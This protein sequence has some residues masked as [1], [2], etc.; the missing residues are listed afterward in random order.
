MATREI[1]WLQKLLLNLEYP[2]DATIIIYSNNINN[3]L[4]VNKLHS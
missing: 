1:I 2:M 3:I 4:L